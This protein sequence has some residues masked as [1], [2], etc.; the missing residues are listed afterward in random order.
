MMRSFSL[1]GSTLVLL[2]F[3]ACGDDDD[4]SGDTGVAAGEQGTEGDTEAS[5]V[6]ATDES[7]ATDET[8]DTPTDEGGDPDPGS[9]DAGDDSTPPDEMDGPDGGSSES[10]STPEPVVLMDESGESSIEITFS[11]DGTQCGQELCRNAR[12][13]G[14]PVGVEGCCFDEA[15]SLCGFDMTVLGIALNLSMP[16]CEPL[17][18]PGNLDSACPESEPVPVLLPDAPEDGVVMDGCCQ[19]NGECGFSA[20]FGDF[21]FGC[22]APGRFNQDPTGDCQPE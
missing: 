12:I 2:A 5:D 1:F 13:E 21:G 11:E 9:V 20:D 18:A 15:E 10:D 8:D 16:G 3:V 17:D 6:G 14:L 22:V 19:A 4:S 7:T